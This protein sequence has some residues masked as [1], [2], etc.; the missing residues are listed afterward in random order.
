[1]GFN[2]NIRVGDTC[3]TYISDMDPF[4]YT[5]FAAGRR[6][7]IGQV[8]AMQE[9]KIVLLRVCSLLTIENEVLIK[10]RDNRPPNKLVGITFKVRPN[11]LRQQF[12][13]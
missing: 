12:S 11:A 1:M 2:L 5:P 8:F 6:N 10:D 7:C 9:M 13:S 4:W 3:I